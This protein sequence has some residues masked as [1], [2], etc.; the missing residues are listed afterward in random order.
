LGVGFRHWLDQSRLWVAHASGVAYARG[1]SL[2]ANFY[3]TIRR[4]AS[5]DRKGISFRLFAGFC[6]RIRRGIQKDGLIKQDLF[7]I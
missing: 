1:R 4:G 3:G 2:S 6:G 7:V 5:I